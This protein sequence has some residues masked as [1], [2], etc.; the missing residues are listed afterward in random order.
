MVQLTRRSDL[1]EEAC[2]KA[3]PYWTFHGAWLRSLAFW[4]A[5]GEQDRM[6]VANGQ[7]FKK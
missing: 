6:G 4:R 2:A 3:V 5:R 1:M 7:V